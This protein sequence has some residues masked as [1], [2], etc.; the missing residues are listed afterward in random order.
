MKFILVLIFMM[1]PCLAFGVNDTFYI[2][3]VDTIFDGDDTLVADFT[4]AETFWEATNTDDN[5]S[6][7]G[8]TVFGFVRSDREF[9][10]SLASNVFINGLDNIGLGEAVYYV[11]VTGGARHS[12]DWC[13]TCYTLVFSATSQ[14]IGSFEYSLEIEGMQFRLL[15]SDNDGIVMFAD[16]DVR[17]YD[18]LFTL[19]DANAID[20]NQAVNHRNTLV[21]CGFWD[22]DSSAGQAALLATSGATSADW[23]VY[24]STFKHMREAFQHQNGAAADTVIMIGNLLSGI[25]RGPSRRTMGGSITNGI[26]AFDID[27]NVYDDS[28]NSGDTSNGANN[29]WNQTFTFNSGDPSDS[30][31]RLASNDVGAVDLGTNL[32]HPRDP[33]P[34]LLWPIT[35]FDAEGDGRPAYE[36][37][38]F[39][40]A[41]L[42]DGFIYA[43]DQ[44]NNA[45]SHP[46]WLTGQTGAVA[47]TMWNQYIW[48]DI[49]T[50]ST[51]DYVTAYLY[52][53]VSV[54]PTVADSF[55]I[56]WCSQPGAKNFVGDNAF[57]NADSAEMNWVNY[58]EDGDNVDQSSA[59]DSAWTT[60][61][62]DWAGGSLATINIP[63]TAD[64]RVMVWQLDLDSLAMD[65]I[66]KGTKGNYGFW[67]LSQDR[68]TT[69]DERVRFYGSDNDTLYNRPRLVIVSDT[70]TGSIDLWDAGNDEMTLAAA[71]AAVRHYIHGPEG[72]GAYHGVKKRTIH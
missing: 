31:F 37:Q 71:I 64:E 34:S 19:P 28:A 43:G 15:G 23:Y 54:P 9:I 40:D 60:A 11:R 4:S 47:T 45:G 51:K 56:K 8:D 46:N 55:E 53:K 49:D 41:A 21:N 42:L 2:Q 27:Y 68:S 63:T 5:V 14:T 70:T 7:H 59:N 32:S 52:A 65:S 24:S 18:C 13:D 29:D 57:T 66:V 50:A 72:L 44:N 48:A 33:F 62:G 39:R 35:T 16:N 10:D 1:L 58:H 6:T 22:T 12:G 36:V 67:V 30:T 3:P 20:A 17:L 25:D 69:Q 38:E 61:G 26:G